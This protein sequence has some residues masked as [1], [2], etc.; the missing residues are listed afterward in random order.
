MEKMC[1]IYKLQDNKVENYIARNSI[2]N[3]KGYLMES[4]HEIFNNCAH[5]S[6]VAN[7]EMK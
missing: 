7:Y 1:V 4:I 6:R 5:L 3:N 2:N